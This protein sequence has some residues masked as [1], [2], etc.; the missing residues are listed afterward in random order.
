MNIF[1]LDNDPHIAAS[2]HCDKHVVKMILESVQM[3][4]TVRVRYGA[5]APYKPCHKHHPCT[6]WVGASRDNYIW[7]VELAL[8]LGDE[9]KKRYGK[10]HLS[11]IRL[12][13]ILDPPRGIP[14]IGLTEFVQ[15][16]PDAYKRP[17]DAV[18][19]YRTYYINDKARFATWTRGAS[20][21]DWWPV[22][23]AA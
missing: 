14:D 7:L 10:T 9:F 12:M 17:A 19:A 4:S 5:S 8:A 20:V 16:M 6:L 3:L 11:I 13:E 18:E 1:V 21:P 23:S 15:A 22:A 2:Q